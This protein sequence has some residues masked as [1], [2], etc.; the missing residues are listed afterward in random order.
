MSCLFHQSLCQPNHPLTSEGLTYKKAAHSNSH[1]QETLTPCVKPPLPTPCTPT[2][3]LYLTPIHGSK[4]G[5]PC[6]AP[7][8]MWVWS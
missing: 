1:L 6:L 2:P 4:W 3:T 8:G 7:P 5:A